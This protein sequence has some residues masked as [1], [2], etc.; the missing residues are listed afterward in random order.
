MEN[1]NRNNVAIKT[2][3]K[4]DID[5]PSSPKNIA[6]IPQHILP[7]IS[8]DTAASPKQVRRSKE[9]MRRKQVRSALKQKFASRQQNTKQHEEA[10]HTTTTSDILGTFKRM[11]ITLP[12]IATNIPSSS[13]TLP[14]TPQPPRNPLAHRR[15]QA[16]PSHVHC[17]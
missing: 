3:H 16:R 5:E 7:I 9:A 11:H 4:S 6:D 2:E 13:L 8:R 17:H 12:P 10:Q 14:P 1:V 15:H